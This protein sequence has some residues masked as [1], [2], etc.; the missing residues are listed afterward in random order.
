MENIIE[1]LTAQEKE[2]LIAKKVMKNTT[3]FH[4][5]DHCSSIGIIKT[6]HVVISSF[7]LTG[8]EIIYN[9]L[10]DNQ[11]FGNNLIFSSDPYYKG[12]VIAKDNSEIIFINKEQLITLLTKNK[13]F[14]NIY[15]MYESDFA[16]KLNATIKLLSF[17]SA[18][19][20]FL[21]YME[22]NNNYIK[23]KSITSLAN[24]LQLSRE[25]LSRLIHKLKKDNNIII[26]NKNIRLVK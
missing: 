14:L 26:T 23:I 1:T 19:E 5:G 2:N 15:L 24:I 13:N 18:Y 10:Y 12:D 4:E 11:M 17:D 7:S 22:I 16:K 9:S 8:K 25:T 6:G 3:I 20:R 21:Y